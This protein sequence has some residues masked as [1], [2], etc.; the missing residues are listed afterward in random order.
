MQPVLSELE[1]RSIIRVCDPV[2]P[3]CASSGTI[4]ATTLVF[5]LSEFEAEIAA[6]S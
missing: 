6:R 3:V 2:F 4:R 1:G 5:G